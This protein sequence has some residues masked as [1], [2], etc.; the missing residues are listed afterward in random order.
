VALGQKHGVTGTP[1]LVF[2]NSERVPGI[3]TVQEL[4]KKFAAVGRRKG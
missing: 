1:S 3:L 2:E 4:E